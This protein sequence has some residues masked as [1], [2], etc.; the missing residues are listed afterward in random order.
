MANTLLDGTRSI[1]E[2]DVDVARGDAPTDHAAPTAPGSAAAPRAPVP[3]EGRRERFLRA[4]VAAL[5]H[6]HLDWCVLRGHDAFPS[7]GPGRDLDLVVAPE[8]AARAVSIARE[9]ARAH[10]VST[11]E[12]RR[13]GDLEEL[14]FHAFEG[15]GRH[16]FFG[17]DLHRAEACFGVRYANAR[18]VLAG[19]TLERGLRRPRPAIAACV[20]AFGAFLS[21]G[22]LPARH[23]RE[24]RTAVLRD[25]SAV[26]A[27]LARWFGAA[28]AERIVATVAAAEDF[29]GALDHRALR[30]A[31]LVRAAARAPLGAF[32]GALRHAWNA[33]VVPLVRP[34]GRFFALLGTDGSGKSTVLRGVLDVLLPAFGR[35]RLHDYHLRPM[36]L[37]QLNALLHGGRTTYSLA[38]MAD[39]HRA[40]PSGRVGSNLRAL[41]YA[42][43][44]VLGYALRILPLRRRACVVAFD[45]YAHDY[46]VDPLRSRIRRDSLFLRPLCALCPA[47]DRLYVCL[48]P[49][50]VVRARKQELSLEE[51][52]LQIERYAALA[53]QHPRARRI[54][55]STTV[56]A[57]VDAILCDLFAEERA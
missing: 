22:A 54:D 15:P 18:H 57:A 21:G 2:R 23:A 16:A 17:L 33:R 12:H 52:R 14:H 37:P 1:D 10:G 34:R 53:E 7:P 25:P 30:R 44:W 29:A 46:L 4:Y 9:L 36:L 40:R 20:D 13:L 8:H 24:L 19:T 48:A 45:R 26:R 43:D 42:A 27:E 38:D 47:P 5:E 28:R 55:T 31:L 3:E 50:D 6:E 11:W 56:E 39:P 51:S 32:A 35:E 41:W 49:L